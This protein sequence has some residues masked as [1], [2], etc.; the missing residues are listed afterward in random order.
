MRHD[1]KPTLAVDTGDRLFAAQVSRDGA[2]EKEPDDLAVT[3]AD[4]L[5]DDHAKAVG[6]LAQSESA[7]DGV[8]VGRADDVDARGTHRA[9]QLRDRRATVRRGL[10]VRVHVHANTLRVASYQAARPV[11]VASAT[12]HGLKAD[13]FARLGGAGPR[14]IIQA[15]RPV[16]GAGPRSIMWSGPSFFM[17]LIDDCAH[18]LAK[19]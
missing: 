17:R 2:L 15:A 13:G 8:V 9:G 6:E 16:G 18:A 10:A 19:S 4:L 14:S 11:G 12:R 1:G 3:R 5:T 7:I